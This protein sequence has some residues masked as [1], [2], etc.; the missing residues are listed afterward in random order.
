M[1]HEAK[2]RLRCFALKQPLVDDTTGFQRTS[3]LAGVKAGV[4]ISSKRATASPCPPPSKR[5]FV[6][7]EVWHTSVLVLPEPT[8]L[9]LAPEPALPELTLDGGEGT[10]AKR[11]APKCD[12]GLEEDDPGLVSA[13]ERNLLEF[14]Q[15]ARLQWLQFEEE[16]RERR[17]RCRVCS[18][19]DEK[20]NVM[21]DRCDGVYHLKCVKLK[22]VPIGEWSCAECKEYM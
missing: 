4:T 5:E 9:R 19:N 7:D 15:K 18:V 6:A 14:A 3:L 17:D 20:K 10:V 2:V 22:N 16:R 8:S 12:S 11:F 1:S 21:C 13:S